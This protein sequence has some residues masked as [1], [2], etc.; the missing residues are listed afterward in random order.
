MRVGY[1]SA[2]CYGQRYRN[3]IDRI[4]QHFSLHQQTSCGAITDREVDFSD[5]GVLPR[6][7]CILVQF[8]DIAKAHSEEQADHFGLGAQGRLQSPS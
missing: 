6:I 1:K 5:T 7:V 3:S 4:T 8:A 2:D